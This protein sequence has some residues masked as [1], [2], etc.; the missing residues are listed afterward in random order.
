LTNNGLT[1]VWDSEAALKIAK[2]IRDRGLK[3]IPILVYTWDDNDQSRLFVERFKPAGYT[4]D[5][6]VVLGFL[7]D[8][9]NKKVGDYS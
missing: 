1:Y 7:H 3:N 4:D 5:I 6:T 2:H 8:F 9:A